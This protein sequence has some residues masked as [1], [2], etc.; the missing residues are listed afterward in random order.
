MKSRFWSLLLILLSLVIGGCYSDIED[1]LDPTATN[2]NPEADEDCCCKYPQIKT[3][4]PGPRVKELI[5]MEHVGPLV[6]LPGVSC[7]AA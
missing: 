2:F 1:C 4:L 3:P 7:W 6:D 5:G